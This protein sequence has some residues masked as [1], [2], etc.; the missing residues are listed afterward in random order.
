MAGEFFSLGEVL[1]MLLE[2]SIP[3]EPGLDCA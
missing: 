3:R 1:A 2:D